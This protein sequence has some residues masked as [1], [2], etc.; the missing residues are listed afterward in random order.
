[1]TVQ[2]P[3]F[4]IERMFAKHEFTARVNLT[5]SD[6]EALTL[7]E[8]WRLAPGQTRQWYESLTLG[9]TQSPGHPILR[10]LA[11]EA[12]GLDSAE[13]VQ[14]F[15]GATE[16]VFV[17]LNTVLSAG[18]HVI[19]IG[20]TYQLLLDVPAA[21]GAEVT[22]IQLRRE[23]HWHLDVA[24]IRK[25]IRPSTRLIIANFPH[26]PTGALPELAV[27]EDLIDL[28]DGTDVL[29]LSDEIYRGI[30]LDPQ[31]RRP[32]A[33]SLTPNA[34][35][36]SGVSKTLG[37]AGVRIGW[38]ATQNTNVTAGLL[39]YRYWTTL[40]TSAPS[41]VLAIAGLQ[42]A[43]ALLE[44]ANTIVRTNAKLLASFIAGTP[45]GDWVPPVGGTCAYP[46]LTTTHA[47]AFSAWL[48]EHH[49]VLL[50][51]DTMFKHAGHHL[52]FGLGRTS[53]HEGIATLGQAW[54]TWLE[55]TGP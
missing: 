29:L 35:S 23:D 47:Q 21:I 33:A 12:S 30:E 4:L 46:W 17:L 27:F 10:Q 55:Q 54:P 3:P 20:P 2:L 48:V 53:V 52:R 42:A 22:E 51:P 45:G 37:M 18:D 13:A 5:G 26:N 38:T 25:A 8:L 19:V 28:V 50:A 9:Y 1:M 36:V 6:T 15:A 16:A 39:D 41:E 40:A 44:R 7:E 32:S 31:R 14:V 11:A 49:G 43:P 24:E 34:V